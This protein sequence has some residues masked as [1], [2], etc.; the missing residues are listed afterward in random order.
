MENAEN[1][2]S[3]GVTAETF[4]SLE[5]I[6]DFR[7]PNELKEHITEVLFFILDNDDDKLID[8]DVIFTLRLFHSLS[9][10]LEKK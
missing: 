4:R 1:S 10:S 8:K 3:Y 9:S 6:K 5:D 7:K 2:H